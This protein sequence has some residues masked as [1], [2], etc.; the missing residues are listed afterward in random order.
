MTSGRN[1]NAV[2]M[3]ANESASFSS[4]ST[5]ITSASTC[6]GSEVK[7]YGVDNFLRILLRIVNSIRLAPVCFLF[8]VSVRK[9][10]T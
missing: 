4:H 1:A 8:Y 9:I 5:S 10:R 2:L 3:T 6:Y 7:V